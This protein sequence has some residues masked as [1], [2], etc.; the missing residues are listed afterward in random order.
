MSLAGDVLKPAPASRLNVQIGPRRKLIRHR[1]PL[2]RL[3]EVKKR[4][5][6][7]LN[8]VVLA[9]SAGALRRFALRHGDEP[10]DLRVMVP[11]SLRSVDDP[12]G[13]GNRITFAFV[14][15]PVSEPSAKARLELIRSRTLELK[16]S[17]RVAGTD[18]LLRSAGALPEP[19]KRRAAR[20]VASPRLY[21]LTIS[22]VPGPR[23]PLFAAGARVRT[24]YPV[25][26]I[27]DGHALSIGVLTYDDS[28]H[29]AAY[30]DPDAL[31]GL[32]RLQVMFEDA[33][34]EL[35][36]AGSAHSEPVRLRP[37]ASG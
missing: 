18:V 8:D 4:Y 24:I 2:P 12:T 32:G 9:V 35:R 13:Q 10:A 11:I 37:A 15:L 33:V 28:V 23:F 25:I 26:P 36:A 3:M 20:L 1:V 34:E 21:N 30:A 29:F 14:E 5:G 16:S 22:N 31:S 27:P 7:T 19:L 6:V 17:G